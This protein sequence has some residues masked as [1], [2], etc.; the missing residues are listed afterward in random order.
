MISICPTEQLFLRQSHQKLDSF[1]RLLFPL[2]KCMTQITSF[3]ICVYWNSFE[4]SFVGFSFLFPK[5]PLIK[6]IRKKP[7]VVLSSVSFAKELQSYPCFVYF[8]FIISFVFIQLLIQVFIN[9]IKSY[10]FS[11]SITDHFIFDEF[12]ISLFFLFQFKDFH[13]DWSLFIIESDNL[14]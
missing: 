6:A 3:F 12:S 11:R 4:S 10:Y 9:L 13:G 2:I 1:S 8:V 14:Q 5:S 7:F